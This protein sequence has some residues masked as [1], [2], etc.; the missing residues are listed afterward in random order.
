M[1]ELSPDQKQALNMLLDFVKTSNPAKQF[2][3]LG[4]YAGT[5]KT[6][7]ISELRKRINTEHPKINVAFCAFTGKA[8]QVLKNKLV[9]NQAL[10]KKDEISTIHGLIYRTIEDDRGAVVGWERKELDGIEA[11]LIIVDEASMVDQKIWSDL[12]SYGKPI[13]AVGDHGQLPPISGNFNLMSSPEHK[14]EKIHRQASENPIIQISILARENGKI[15]HQKWAKNIFKV[16]MS[17]G[18]EYYEDLFSSYNQDTLVLCN[19]NNTRL[20]LNQAIRRHLGF[21]GEN[22]Q[23]ND[24]VICL[25]NNHEKQIFNG[26]QGYLKF[27]KAKNE[28]A[29]DVE[30]DMDGALRL[31]YGLISKDQFNSET[32]LN[33]INRSYKTQGLD[34]FDFGYALTVHKSQGSQAKKVIL[35]E[36]RNKHQS[37]EDFRRWLYTAV[38]RAEESLIIFGNN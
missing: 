36:E 3:T 37:D 5:G 34:L 25:R 26:M 38:T 29:Y 14:L 32:T 21:E 16:P 13:I 15:P 2:I 6:T 19:F 20:R 24:R 9:T 33:N 8:V 12:L 10:L 28:L 35:F 23:K 1:L 22:P 17:E 27:I 18:H 7:I 4:G 30:V 31:Y 11:D